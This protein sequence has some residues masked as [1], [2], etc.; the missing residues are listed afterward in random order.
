MRLAQEERPGAV[1]LELPE[2]IA[3][4]EVEALPFSV[5]RTKRPNAHGKAVDQA[6]EMINESSMPLLLI[7][8]AANRH[9]TSQALTRFIEK[10][11]I[12]FSIHKW[13][14]GLWM[15]ATPFSWVQRLS[16]H[17]TIYT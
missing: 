17:T 15:N 13:A 3:A 14:K 11:R 10:T 12:H 6:V 8:A 16:Q 1:H 2:D 5:H 7:G 9:R 4:E